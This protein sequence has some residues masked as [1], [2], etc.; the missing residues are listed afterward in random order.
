STG[1]RRFSRIVK[2]SALFTLPKGLAHGTYSL[3][4]TANGIASD[5]V[6]FTYGP[7]PEGEIIAQNT[8]SYNDN[9]AASNISRSSIY[10][11]PANKE[12]TIQFSLEK[13][14]AI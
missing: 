7:E 8:E 6:S 13:T 2:D 1:V 4:V 10:P 9:I 5:A 3:V 11:N 14:S 12:T